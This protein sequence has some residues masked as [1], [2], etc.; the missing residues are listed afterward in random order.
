MITDAEN[1]L[2]LEHDEGRLK[3]MLKALLCGSEEDV[4]NCIVLRNA[5][6]ESFLVQVA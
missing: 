6:P 1:E 3:D 4:G 2:D 5:A